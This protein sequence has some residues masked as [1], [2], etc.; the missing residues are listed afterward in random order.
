MGAAHQSEVLLQH[1]ELGFEL[2]IPFPLSVRR[3]HR[4]DDACAATL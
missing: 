2:T 4:I 1:G 3:R